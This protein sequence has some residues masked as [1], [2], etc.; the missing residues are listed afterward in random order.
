MWVGCSVRWNHGRDELIIG[1][2]HHALSTALCSVECQS[3][4]GVWNLDK[5]TS[6]RQTQNEASVPQEGLA[7]AYNRH[8]E[9]ISVTLG[10][11]Q[12]C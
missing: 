9:R 10:G 6:G 1:P 7:K 11:R 2:P 12:I 8:S 3:D 4:E 5:T